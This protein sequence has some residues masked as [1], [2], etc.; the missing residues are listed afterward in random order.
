M[1]KIS[2]HSRALLLKTFDHHR[3]PKDFA[4]PMYNYLVY[5]FHPGSCFSAVLANDL[6]RAILSSHPA[7]TIEAFKALVKWVY[8]AVPL[9]ARGTLKAVHAWCE[10]SAD[11]R[12]AVL[13]EHKLIFTGEEETWKVLKDDPVWE[14]HRW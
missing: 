3:V 7:N 14:P 5:G 2:P 8:D 12:R 13:E 1:M 9:Q 6:Q 11:E 10:L 4:D